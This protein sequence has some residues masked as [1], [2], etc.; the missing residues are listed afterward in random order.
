M[1]E[2]AGGSQGQPS[3]LT[4]LTTPAADFEVD[5]SFPAHAGSL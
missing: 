5:S 4:S 2:D 3:G 1:L